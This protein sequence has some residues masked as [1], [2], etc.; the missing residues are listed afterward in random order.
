MDKAERQQKILDLIKAKRVSSQGELVAL[1]EKKGIASTQASVSR[2]LADLGVVK[3]GGA[4]RPP[5]LRPGQSAIVDR[6]TVDKAGDNLVVV[7]T[8]PGM[9]QTV[10]VHL[11]RT[12]IPGLVGTIAGDDTIFLAI[13]SR[14]DQN[15]VI[16]KVL[17]L[18]RDG[19]GS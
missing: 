19:P 14:D 7:R 11:D 17:S 1:L 16:R 5:A 8:G 4:Y 2:D 12:K 18:F 13:A 10:A 9:A 3:E 6:L 15:N